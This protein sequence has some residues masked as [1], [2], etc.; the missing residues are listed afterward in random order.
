METLLD[1]IFETK[2]LSYIVAVVG[3]TFLAARAWPALKGLLPGSVRKLTEGATIA[4]CFLSGAI[5][6]GNPT[7]RTDGSVLPLGAAA[8]SMVIVTGLLSERYESGTSST[9]KGKAT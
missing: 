5:C 4:S 1:F 9:A 6:F 3:A 7:W 2:K 8:L